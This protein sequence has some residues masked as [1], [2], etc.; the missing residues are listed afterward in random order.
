MVTQIGFMK[1]IASFC[2]ASV[3]ANYPVRYTMESVLDLFISAANMP[4]VIHGDRR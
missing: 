1:S 2:G 4:N 3:L